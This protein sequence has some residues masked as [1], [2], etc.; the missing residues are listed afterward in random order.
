[1]DGLAGRSQARVQGVAGFGGHHLH[2]NMGGHYAADRERPP[3]SPALAMFDLP[4]NVLPSAQ[5]PC[6]VLSQNAQV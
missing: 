4:V 5:P 2:L 3:V 1:M 6:K